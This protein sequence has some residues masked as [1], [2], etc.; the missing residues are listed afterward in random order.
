MVNFQKEEP[1]NWTVWH[2]EDQEPMNGK[3]RRWKMKC[4]LCLC[5]LEA[6]VVF[7]EHGLRL[8]LSCVARIHE[9]AI[10]GTP[11]SECKPAPSANGAG[12]AFNPVLKPSR[13]DM[14]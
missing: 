4:S 6:A 9:H 13:S 7:P 2:E 8:C 3:G 14:P 1:A 10:N 5:E 11:I 12:P